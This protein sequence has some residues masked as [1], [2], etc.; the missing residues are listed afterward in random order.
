MPEPIPLLCI[1][2]KLYNLSYA[3]VSSVALC[4]CSLPSS[5]VYRI[6][7]ARILK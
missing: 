4:D 5:S 3:H 6:F 7:E 2:S 1:I